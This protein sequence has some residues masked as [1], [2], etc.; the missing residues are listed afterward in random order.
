MPVWCFVLLFFLIVIGA[1]VGIRYNEFETFN[2]FHIV[3]TVLF[4]VNMAVCYWEIC[5]HRHLDHINARMDY[6]RSEQKSKG[7]SPAAAYLTTRL[8]LSPTKVL[9]PK[10]WAEIYAAYAFYDPAYLDRKS[11]GFNIDIGNGYWT[12]VPTLILIVNFTSPFLPAFVAGIIG[13]ALFYQWIYVTGLYVASFFV[14]QQHKQLSR[15]E[16]FLYIWMINVAWIAISVIGFYVS[17]RLVLD[18]N[19]GVLGF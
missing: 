8:S 12:L 2:A 9:S 5:L 6:W 3:L 1:F 4:A 7:I 18:Q 10:F 15:G 19:Y 13:L 16:V 11:A 17:L 14:G